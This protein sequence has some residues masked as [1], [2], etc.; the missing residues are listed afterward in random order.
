M[1]CIVNVT[2]DWGIGNGNGLLVNIPEDMKWF[3]T[4]TRGKILIMGRKTLDSFP[5]GKPLKN[6]VNIVISRKRENGE[7]TAAVD[8]KTR[9]IYVKSIDEA[10]D[11]AHEIIDENWPDYTDEDIFVIGGASIYAAMLP[12]I[13]TAIVTKTDTLLPADA[14]FPDLDSDPSWEMSEC[15]EEKEHEGLKFRFCTYKRK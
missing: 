15:S 13:D 14:F 11:T 1:K 2:N 10:I 7:N 12:F 3:R 4:Q 5:G 9:L 6:R 8:D